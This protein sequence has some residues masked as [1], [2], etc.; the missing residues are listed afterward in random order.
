MRR[1]Y[2]AGIF[3]AVGLLLSGCGVESGQDVVSL[4]PHPL[5]ATGEGGEWN[6]TAGTGAASYSGDSAGSDSSLASDKIDGMDT[7]TDLYRELY[8]QAVNEG[9]DNTW[10]SL[11]YLDADDIPELVA[12]DNT[13]Y[14]SYSIYTVNDGQLFCMADSLSTVEFTY[15]EKSGVI[16]EFDRWNGGG[17]EGGYGESYYQVSRTQALTYD[18]DTPPLLSY[19]YN[20]VYDGEG[21]YTGTGVTDYYHKGNQ[22]DEAEYQ[23]LLDSLGIV[24]DREK[25]CMENAYSKEEMLELLR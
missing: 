13:D 9:S 16:A 3:V 11:I 17:D 8:R 24:A 6:G 22:I 5:E 10:Y 21:A 25:L 14:D 15:Y 7:E 18:D 19:S 20:A 4:E 23:A 12:R 1:K 2:L